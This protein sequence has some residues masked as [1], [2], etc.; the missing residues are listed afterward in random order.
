MPLGEPALWRPTFENDPTLP[1]LS[2][3]VRE[4]FTLALYVI[5]TAARSG[6]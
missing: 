5:Q 6:H 1:D 4:S 3:E 2:S